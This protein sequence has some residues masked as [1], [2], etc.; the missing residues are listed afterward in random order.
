MKL[1][2]NT[3]RRIKYAKMHETILDSKNGARHTKFIEVAIHVVKQ[4]KMEVHFVIYLKRAKKFF[5][6]E[7]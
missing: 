5:E 7:Y 6:N 4:N 3:V 1:H 2:A